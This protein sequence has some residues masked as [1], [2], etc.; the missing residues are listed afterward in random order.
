MKGP[1]VARAR[2]VR[3]A[4]AST[5]ER[6]RNAAPH[7]P[8]SSTWCA[9]ASHASSTNRSREVPTSRSQ[10]GHREVCQPL[11]APEVLAALP[12]PLL[13]DREA[14]PRSLEVVDRPE[15]DQRERRLR[16]VRAGP[17]LQLAPLLEEVPARA[18]SQPELGPEPIEDDLGERP[19]IALRAEHAIAASACSTA[20]LGSCVVKLTSFG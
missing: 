12:V 7:G 18:V 20:R 1:I 13:L 8:G 17:R 10:L 11:R 3:P 16:R 9:S 2:S 5:S 14:G 15:A 19:R 4:W 6:M